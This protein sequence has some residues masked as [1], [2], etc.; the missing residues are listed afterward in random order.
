MTPA[1]KLYVPGA[2]NMVPVLAALFEYAEQQG[3]RV[4]SSADCHSPDD[5]EFSQFPPH[6]VA[7][8]RGQAKIRQTLLPD[9]VV[10]EADQERPQ[11][12]ALLAEH[13]QLIL[14][15][16]TFD[17]FDNANADRLVKSIGVG[18]YVVFGVATHCRAAGEGS[19]GGSCGRCGQS[20][21]RGYRRRGRRRVDRRGGSLV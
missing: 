4:V 19:T 10:V 9:H 20:G 2:E 7:G 15:K 12:A 5:P 3:I 16:R 6:C 21:R 13:Q 1:G 11:M 18:R 8:T 17:L 14:N